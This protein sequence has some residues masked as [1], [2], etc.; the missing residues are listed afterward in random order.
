MYGLLHII[1]LLGVAQGYSTSLYGVNLKDQDHDR[2][3]FL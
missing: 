3:N 1:I 2:S